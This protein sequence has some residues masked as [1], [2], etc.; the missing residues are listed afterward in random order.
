MSDT[1]HAD[2]AKVTQALRFAGM[3]VNSI[4]DLVNTRETY[5]MAIPILIRMLRE[6]QHP[7]IKEGIARAL[8]VKEAKTVANDLIEEFRCMN[9]TDF[10][11]AQV[12]WAIGN[13][14]SAAASDEV[15]ES[16]IGLMEDERHGSA[17]AML[18]LALANARKKRRIAIDALL[19]ALDEDIMACQAAEALAKLKA[20]EA[21]GPLTALSRHANRD[22]QKAAAKA[23]KRLQR[24][25][26]RKKG[27]L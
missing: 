12:K 23:L 24:V 22:I 8:T 7:R 18:P 11:S 1:L 5:P 17:R 26:P 9:P 4:Y 15:I 19:H 13:A 14:L 2:D 6:V 27:R 25:Q 3:P 20:V 10:A 21:M 16:V